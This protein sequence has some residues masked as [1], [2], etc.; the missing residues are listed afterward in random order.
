MQV[1][2]PVRGVCGESVLSCAGTLD[3]SSYMTLR[4]SV[5]DAALEEPRA[6]IVD[7]SALDVPATTAWSAITS[8]HWHVHLWPNIPLMLVCP[9]STVRAVLRGTGITRQVPVYRSVADA[10]EACLAQ[11]Q[12]RR[13]RMCTHLPATLLSAA[14]ARRLVH[15]W[16]TAWSCPAMIS[17]A[18]T[19]ATELV[20]NTLLHTNSAPQ[21]TIEYDGELV[22]VAVEDTSRVRAQRREDAAH[23]INPVSGLAVVAALSRAW[24][25]TPKRTGKTVWAV[26]G[27]ENAL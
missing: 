12:P 23:G 4:D 26:F 21:L 13:E 15:R 27:P 8:A 14:H 16:L 6:V 24:G 18:A 25:C 3:G 20:E 19:V 17:A 9:D 10:R 5:I 11:R 22:A 7:A 1:D 2:G